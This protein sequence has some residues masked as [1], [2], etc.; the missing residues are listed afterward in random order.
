MR[1]ETDTAKPSAP[2]TPSEPLDESLTD[3]IDELKRIAFKRMLERRPAPDAF[4]RSGDPAH[5][6][7][8]R[9]S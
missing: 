3:M 1:A 5:A 8:A 4:L 7:R 9:S 2:V 6:A